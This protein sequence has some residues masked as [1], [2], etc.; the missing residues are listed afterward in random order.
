[1]G[2]T[3]VEFNFF[4]EQGMIRMGPR[5][6]QVVKHGPMSGRWTLEEAGQVVAEA[7]KPNAFFRSFE[8]RAE[9]T[10]FTVEAQSPFVRAFDIRVEGRTVG[11]IR[12]AHPFTRRAFVECSPEVS[13]AG[14]LFSFWLAALAWRRAANSQ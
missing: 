8:L 12:P 6:M 2:S 1:L 11:T 9:S 13:E 10:L 3:A 7:Q 5:T 14:Q 4:T